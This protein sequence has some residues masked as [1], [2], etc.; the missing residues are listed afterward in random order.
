M[1]KWLTNSLRHEPAL[2][3]CSGRGAGVSRE[4]S[5]A[6]A[7]VRADER[8]KSLASGRKGLSASRSLAKLSTPPTHLHSYT[9]STH[10]SCLAGRV[11]VFFLDLHVNV[12]ELVSNP[13][14][15]RRL[16]AVMKLRRIEL[17]AI[18]PL[19]IGDDEVGLN[20]FRYCV[21]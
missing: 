13:S 14:R 4:L 5:D 17:Y 7:R 11:R 1:R 20:Q 21:I 2:P 10:A 18:S 19:E 3:R 12:R 9:G 15:E 8:P 16:I 6:P